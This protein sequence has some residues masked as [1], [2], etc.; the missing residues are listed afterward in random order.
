VNDGFVVLES[1]S[2][3]NQMPG[4]IQLY[5]LNGELIISRPLLKGEISTRIPMSH[6]PHG[7]YILRIISQSDKKMVYHAKIIW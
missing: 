5:N 7:F 2:D 1:D 6:L 3:T 4:Y